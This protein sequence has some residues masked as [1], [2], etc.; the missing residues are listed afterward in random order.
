MCNAFVLKKIPDLQYI[1]EGPNIWESFHAMLKK[2][3]FHHSEIAQF[4][5]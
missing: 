3:Y 2:N 1:T 5:Q 4:H